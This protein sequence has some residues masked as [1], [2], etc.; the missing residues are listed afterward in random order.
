MVLHLEGLERPELS[1]DLHQAPIDI[2][3]I[4]LVDVIMD[5]IG[6][7]GGDIDHGI[8][9]GGTLLGGQVII[10]VLGITLPCILVVV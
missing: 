5:I 2:H 7:V 9:D 3:L 10:I 6:M 8:G 1:Q 4:I